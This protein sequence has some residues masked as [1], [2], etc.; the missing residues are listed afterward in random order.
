MNTIT[1]KSQEIPNFINFNVRFIH[2]SF[3]CQYINFH[4]NMYNG[5]DEILVYIKKHSKVASLLLGK[6]NV[7]SNL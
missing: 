3:L 4:T 6:K 7:Y 5:V 1:L 2:K